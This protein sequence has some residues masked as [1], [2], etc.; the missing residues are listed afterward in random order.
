MVDVLAAKFSREAGI[1]DFQTIMLPLLEF[2]ADG[3]EHSKA[4]AVEHVAVRFVLTEEERKTL[5]PSGGQRVFDNRVGWARTY[6]AKAGLLE[7]TRRGFWR[8]TGRGREVLAERPSRI[9]AN[10]LN[11]FAE[12]REFRALRHRP[13]ESPSVGEDLERE[14]TPEEDLEAAYQRLRQDLAADL[15]ERVRMCSPSFFKRLVVDLLVRMGY[16]GTRQDAGQAIGRSGDEG[17]DGIIK[18]DRLGL[19]AIYL[20]AKRWDE[21]VVRPE[22]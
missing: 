12:F 17:I 4:E 11:R 22:V 13:E 6:M 9:D 21:V 2:A 20:Q 5:L 14:G 16:G 8:I 1:P 10:F 18:E 15:L 7:S 3:R 19:D